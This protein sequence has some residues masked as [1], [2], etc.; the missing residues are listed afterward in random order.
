MHAVERLFTTFAP[1]HYNLNLDLDRPNRHFEGTVEITGVT[2]FETEAIR[3]HA[4]D[5]DIAGATIDGNDVETKL[6]DDVLELHNHEAFPAGSHKISVTFSG[7]ITDAMHGL[8]PCYYEH[9]GLKKELLATQFESHHAREAFPCVDE[10]EAKAT[11]AVTLKTE[12]DIAVLGNMP[13]EEQT[14]GQDHLITQ[15]ART[16][17]MSVYL[18]AWVTGELQ[19]KTAHTKDGVAVSTWATPAQDPGS[20]DFALDVAV[21]SIE[22]FNDYFGIPYPLP[23]ADHVALPD[24]SSG[25]MENWGLITYREIC[26]LADRNTSVS[27]RQFAATVIA[28]ET[29]HQWFGNLVTMKWWDDLWLN[30]SFATLMEYICVDHLFPAWNIW[31]T[32]A[33]NETLSAMRRDYLPGVQPVKTEVKHP[34][35]ISTLF[36]PSIVYA[37]GARLLAMLRDYI[38]NDAFQ[39]GLTK[40]FETHAY[41]NTTGHDLWGALGTT[42]H[43]DIDSFMTPWLEQPGLP[44]VHVTASHNDETAEFTQERFVVGG[45]V[46]SNALWPIPLRSNLSES[47]SPTIF[48]TQSLTVPL[49]TPDLQINIGGRGHFLSHYDD[50]NLLANRIDAIKTGQQPDP[51]DRLTLLH[52]MSLLARAGLAKTTDLFDLTLAYQSETS[53]PVWDIVGLVIGDMKRFVEQDTDA[54]AALKARVVELAQPTFRKLGWTAASDE[55]ETDTKLRATIVGL[56]TYADGPLVIE[57]GLK[58]FRTAEKLSDLPGELRGLIFAIVAKHGSSEDIERLIATHQQTS[59]SELQGDIAAGLCSTH[60]PELIKRLIG[61]MTDESFVRLQDVDHWFVYL[62]RNRYSREATWQ[63]MVDNWQ[64]IQDTF[65]GDKSYDNFV[66][67]GASALSTQQWLERFREFFW[68][69]RSVPA[70]DRAIELGVSDIQGR[71]DWF[72]R[73][74]TELLAHLKSAQ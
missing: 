15:F 50:A 43:L 57:Q 70:L 74:Q 12:K 11:F 45:H 13:V 47:S 52:D 39:Q 8:Y 27:V 60:N 72:E 51:A 56:L 28:H 53:E 58:D 5:L 24:F 63:W 34:D 64:W 33:T 68:E 38:G 46:Q 25:A 29:S 37:K 26:M 3:L 65:A 23:K 16:P 67:Y 10:P 44:V 48:E 61:Y 1:E 55:A 35:E 19:S 14:T 4:K 49:S 42:S 36:D 7:R 73:D 31:M 22:F 71:V 62:M 59:S 2:N 66:R 41:G 20:L 40:Y 18:L 32:F 6:D 54:E 9:D 30:E 17:R 21:R 69:K